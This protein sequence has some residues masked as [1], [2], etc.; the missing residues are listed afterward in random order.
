MGWEPN[1]TGILKQAFR[2]AY[3]TMGPGLC[4]EFG[5]GMGNS[6]VWQAQQIRD[7]AQD[8]VL[9][10]F[11]SFE[12]LPE[13]TPGVWAP[14]RHGK[15]CFSYGEEILREHMQLS[16][17][18]PDDWAF[19]TV[20]GFFEDTLTSALQQEL[21]DAIAGDPVDEGVP[22]MFVNIDVDIHKSTIQALDFIRPMIRVGLPIYFDDW[23][24]PIDIGKGAPAWGEH[25]AWEQWSEANGVKAVLGDTNN[26][27]QRYLIVTEC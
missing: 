22:L 4:L 15:G 24:D 7:W 14:E 23:L 25:L 1:P 18:D 6:Y 26:L 21:L 17:L 8:C 19:R 5:V 12:G 9:I 10:G 2:H 13:E 16:G 20:K 3:N 11:D 27:N